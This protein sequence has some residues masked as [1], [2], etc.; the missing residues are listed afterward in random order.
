[1]GTKRHQQGYILL[2]LLL[3]MALLAI[4]ATVAAPSIV[5]QVKRDREEELVHR[6]IQYRRA[7]RLYVAKTGRYPNTPEALLGSADFRYIRKLY[8]DPITGGDFRML[9]MGDVQPGV[10]LGTPIQPNP[11]SSAD[12]NGNTSTQGVNGQPNP[13]TTA[14]E[15]QISPNQSNQQADPSGVP[16]TGA[17]GTSVPGTSPSFASTS[18]PSSTL[19]TNTSTADG[20]QPGLLIFGVASKSKDRTIREFNKKNHYNDWWFF[21]DPRATAGYEVKG[22]TPP[23]MAIQN[24]INL[25][26]SPQAGALSG[27]QNGLQ[28]G[29]QQGGLQQ[30]A[31]QPA[32]QQSVPQQ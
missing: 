25:P 11:N 30:G 14:Q 18:P 20:Q 24:P 5:F 16:S 27:F 9:H 15:P 1:V 12:N 19:S 13:N 7:V 22:P 8:K 29:L 32:P 26:G 2:T 21:Y 31:S 17:F 10:G 23:A 3:V 28:S 6:G 4:A